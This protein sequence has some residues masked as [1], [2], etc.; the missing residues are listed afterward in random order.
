MIYKSVHALIRDTVGAIG[1]NSYFYHGK[2]SNFNAEQKEV[3]PIVWLD[4]MTCASTFVNDNRT[5]DVYTVRLLFLNL[6][7]VNN[8]SSAS[9]D[10]VFEMDKLARKFIIDLNNKVKYLGDG[11]YSPEI[12]NVR[13]TPF[14][15]VKAS[16]LTGTMLGF[17]L[18]APD[19]VEYC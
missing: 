18:T 13:L 9:N 7:K 10:I 14:I 1:V 15:K 17:N 19:D 16:V 6:D 12:T 5:N 11:A 8:D 3:Y 2:E 4:M